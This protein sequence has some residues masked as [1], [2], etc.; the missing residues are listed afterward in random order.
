MPGFTPTDFAPPHMY[1]DGKQLALNTNVAPHNVAV[2]QGV[3][4]GIGVGLPHTP[5]SGTLPP[6][7][8][9]RSP[10]A[11]GSGILPVS[12]FCNA[13]DTERRTKRLDAVLHTCTISPFFKSLSSTRMRLIHRHPPFCPLLAVSN[14]PQSHQDSRQVRL[15]I[16]AATAVLRP[17]TSTR[18]PTLCLSSESSGS[19]FLLIDC[20]VADAYNRSEGEEEILSIYSTPNNYPTAWSH[21]ANMIT[22]DMGQMT[23]DHR[24]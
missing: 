13:A 6:A 10:I 23:L 9:G 7:L 3:G 2:P 22:G 17:T 24:R 19:C 1:G 16:I 11:P 5:L 14:M 18:A 15:P 4:L 21:G 20:H 8:L 12:L